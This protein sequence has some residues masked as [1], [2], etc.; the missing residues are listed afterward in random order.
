MLTD[1]LQRSAPSRDDGPEPPLV[2]RSPLGRLR[3]LTR[4]TGHRSRT[5]GRDWRREAYPVLQDT[6]AM[7]ERGWVQHR[8]YVH[9]TPPPP[10]LRQIFRGETVR[11][12]DVA[13]ACL[14]GAVVQAVRR[15][16]AIDHLGAAG[17]AL[18]LLW[19]AWQES[20]GF[21]CPAAP[22]RAVPREIRAIRALD[23][24][25]WNDQPGRT[26][27]EVLDLVDRATSRAIMSAMDR[28]RAAMR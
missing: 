13:A 8:S 18:D 21:D 25:R 2:H 14:V 23:L 1:T 3:A 12:D 26:R 22:A 24:A 27:G 11:P 7:I 17:P 15:R 28:P 10:L 4:W 6:R 9:R 20:R 16:G 5:T 19:D